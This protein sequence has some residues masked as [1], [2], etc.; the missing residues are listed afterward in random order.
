M[1][2]MGPARRVGVVMWAVGAMCVVLASCTTE[3]KPTGGSVG[4]LRPTV[5]AS[6]ADAPGA[7]EFALTLTGPDGSASSWAS[8][9]EF[10]VEQGLLAGS[11]RLEATHGDIRRE[12]Y[13]AP[14]YYGAATVAVTADCVTEAT[15][16]CSRR[17]VAYT[18]TRDDS[19]TDDVAESSVILHAYGGGYLAMDY[20]RR[21]P[22]YL[23]HGATDVLLHFKLRNGKEA[24]VLAAR[25]TSAEGADI[26]LHLATTEASATA[27]TITVTVAGE[28]YSVELTDEL[29]DTPLPVIA[30]SGFTPGTPLDITEGIAPTDPV[31]MTVSGLSPLREAVLTVQAPALLE[32]GLH[33]EINLLGSDDATLRTLALAGITV[34]PSADMKTLTVDYTRALPLL[35]VDDAG[36]MPRFSLIALDALGQLSL[37]STLTV[38]VTRAGLSVTAFP[39]VVYGA[40]E[41]GVVIKAPSAEFVHN[42][43]IEVSDGN[44][45]WTPAAITG[46]APADRDGEYRVT[47]TLPPYRE[48]NVQV[49]FS[50][51]GSTF[52]TRT[53]TFTSPEYTIAVDAFA[54][55]AVVRVSAATEEVRSLVTETV[56]IY[57]NGA[58]AQVYSRQPETGLMWITGLSEDT[59]YTFAATIFGNPVASDFTPV[60]EAHTEK[61]EALPNG[62]FEDTVEEIKYE[63]LAQGGL[64][65]QT[66]APLYN[67]Q[68]H[69]DFRVNVPKAPW[70]TVNAKTFYREATNR[71]TWYMQPSTMESADIISGA[72]SVRLVTVAFDPT[73]EEIPPYRQ[74][75][76]PFVAYNPNVPAIKGRAAGKLFIG[77][78]AYGGGTAESYAEGTPFGS[79][80]S[81]INGVYRY[82]PGPG[83]P[84]DCG[85]VDITIGGYVDGNLV[86][87][88]TATGRLYPSVTN[89]TFSVPVTYEMFG[90]KAATLSVMLSSSYDIGDI[91][92]ESSTLRTAPDAVSASSVGSVLEVDNLT[93]SY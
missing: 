11:Y 40:T 71:N 58:W 34:T 41:A 31:T 64:Y 89:G 83:A 36:V 57:V 61:V 87:I 49:R 6:G 1:D 4:Y 90:V 55:H 17:N 7:D 47:F 67:R 69:A 26:N 84:E 39:A 62:G 78:Y 85:R 18:I 27:A 42:L 38:N 22:L 3:D 77:A 5:T 15:V 16:N 25:F 46:T 54:H 48:S 80:P 72:V 86:T 32:H 24:S 43:D 12:G 76:E 70:A 13:E 30:P 63:G 23:R 33:P 29:F 53:L 59:D 82:I 2:N 51:M 37:P 65:S 21:D 79:R 93:L 68:N 92:H 88:A 9:A 60:V 20:D 45:A 50:Y 74:L 35:H 19:Y 56:N 66:A 8:V 44:G 73:G 52:D 14:Y 75:T 28:V 10:P 91:A 81:A